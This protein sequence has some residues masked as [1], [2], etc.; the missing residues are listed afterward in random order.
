[1]TMT[2]FRMLAVTAS[3]LA[4]TAAGAQGIERK[5]GAATSPIASSVSVP[6]GAKIVYLSGSTASPIDPKVTDTPDA[7]G[8]T[9]AQTQSILSKMKAS[10]EAMGLGMGDLVKLTVFLVGDPKLG[11]KMDREGMSKVFVT[12]FGSADQP[13]KPARSTVQVAAL[14][15][16]QIL[17]EIEGIA[18]KAP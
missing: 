7:F 11:G 5:Y 8:D 9:A 18:A 4:A 2:D 16:P 3:M 6:P 15:R 13:N 10:L 1:M 17:V 14:G 12:Y